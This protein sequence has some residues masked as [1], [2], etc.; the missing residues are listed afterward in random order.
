MISPNPWSLLMVLGTVLMAAPLSA[1]DAQVLADQLKGGNGEAAVRLAKLGVKAVPVLVETLKGENDPRVRSQAAWALGEIGAA[2]KDAAPEL[3]RAIEDPEPGLAGQAASALGKLG[4]AGGDKLVDIVRGGKPSAVYAARAIKTPIQG[5]T[6]AL[7]TALNKESALEARIAYIEALGA[8]GRMGAEAVPT[9]VELAGQDGAP[10]VHVMAALGN[11]GEG[12]KT[13]VPFLL[14]LIKK[15]E[16]GPVTLHAVQAIGKIGVRD[17]AIAEALLDLMK[18]GQQPRMALLESLGKAGKVTKE[19][20]PA[21]AQGMRDKDPNV[22]L[23]TAQLVGSLDPNDLA[24][25]SVVMESMM[26]KNPTVR[27]LAAE[28]LLT[29]QPRDPSVADALR[30]LAARDP[31]AAV[32]KAAEAALGKFRK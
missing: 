23:Y 4:L 13:A 21:I 6:P 1:Q 9:L 24:V 11:M 18:D 31:D 17:S 2:A 22:R 7:L 26:D 27:K 28:V 12:A 15:K 8:Q 30:E 29:V 19:S 3:V 16:P 20:L 25:V 10:R 32:R 14:E 5:A